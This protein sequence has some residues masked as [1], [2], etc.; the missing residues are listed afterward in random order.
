[1]VFRL[2]PEGA[3]LAKPA[4]IRM[5]PTRGVV[6]S[7]TKIYTTASTDFTPTET[8]RIDDAQALT[9]TAHFSLWV[10]AGPGSSPDGDASADSG[11][12]NDDA[13]IPN[14]PYPDFPVL[15]PD[16]GF[17]DTDDAGTHAHYTVTAIIGMEGTALN[18]KGH[19]AGRAWKS[20]NNHPMYWD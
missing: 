2:A 1:H 13:G 9:T 19:V 6:D 12:S 8:Q 7:Y 17:I 3:A 5:R 15:P 18:I 20:N 10:L 4:T 16:S 14:W 11:T